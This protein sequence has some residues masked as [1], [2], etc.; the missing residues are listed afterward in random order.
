MKY[1]MY[2]Q[3]PGTANNSTGYNLHLPVPAYEGA[4]CEGT[5]LTT[6]TED[7]GAEAETEHPAIKQGRSSFIKYNN[8]NK[9][10]P[11]RKITNNMN[12]VSEQ[13]TGVT[14]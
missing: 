7:S 8:S 12:K 9:L 5:V 1:E 4:G 13:Q 11:K 10:K 14:V 6:D 2:L 3:A